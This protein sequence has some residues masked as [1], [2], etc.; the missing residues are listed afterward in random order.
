M[1]IFV[2]KEACMG[3]RV[4]EL[5]CSQKHFDV[6]NPQLARLRIAATFPIPSAPRICLQCAKPLCAEACP[7]GA[8][9]RTDTMVAFDEDKCIGCG[10][11]VEACKFDRIWM[12]EFGKPLKCDLCGGDPECIQLCAKH[13]LSLRG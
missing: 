13:A 3:C 6:Y 5:V 12:S 8:L 4:C 11:C 7:A 10:A 2:D 1:N 9:Y